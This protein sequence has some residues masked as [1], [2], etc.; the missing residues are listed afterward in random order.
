[1]K[2][3]RRS[4][5]LGGAA[6][7]AAASVSPLLQG[8]V[9][10]VTTR[11]GL[12]P[13]NFET[14]G[15][16][17]LHIGLDDIKS[18]NVPTKLYTISN[19]QGSELCITNFGARVVSFVTQDRHNKYK[20]VVLGYQDLTH[21]AD[22]NNSEHNYF[23]AIVGR[24]A[25]RIANGKFTIDG[26]EYQLDTNENGNTLHGGKFGLHN[27]TWDEVEYNKNKRLKLKYVSPD[28]EMGFPGELT[29]TV[30][31]SL[32]EDDVIGIYYEATT[33]KATP[34]NLSN[35]TYWC[36]A[37]D[38]EHPITEDPLFVASKQVTPTDEQLIPTGEITDI[39][40]GSSF[41]FF[42]FDATQNIQ[43]R[44]VGDQTNSSN[45]QNQFEGGYDCNFVIM[46]REEFSKLGSKYQGTFSITDDGSNDLD[47][48]ARY[49][50][51]ARSTH[52]GICMDIVSTEPGL[53]F[54]DCHNVHSGNV[55]ME[56]DFN[57]FSAFVLEPQH[58][59]DSPNH[60]N[61]PN[62]ILKPGEIFRSKT[63][64]RFSALAN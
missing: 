37:G 28:G 64:Y 39:P 43:H 16:G 23:G 34:V 30:T 9:S 44:I 20:E 17:T 54:Y 56:P 13:E 42:T 29:V 32:S 18:A 4:F 40:N 53:Q 51:Q 55:E 45:Q 14:K 52:S 27:Q 21:Y 11:S 3:S 61:F 46:P 25:N 59:P 22:Y 36:L 15:V 24:Y 31:Y 12:N 5:V 1:M 33:T 7:L 47:G 38:Y 35:H 63:E 19:S 10:G 49:V 62:T 48:K 58:Y 8:C 50:C 60:T 26:K 6:S 2:I 57:N 41:D